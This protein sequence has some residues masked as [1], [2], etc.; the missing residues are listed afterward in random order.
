MS[1]RVYRVKELVGVMFFLFIPSITGALFAFGSLS[2]SDPLNF[3]SP[4]FTY[5]ITFSFFQVICKVVS[6]HSKHVNVTIQW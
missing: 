6:C 4:F 1:I 5:G 3:G 2:V